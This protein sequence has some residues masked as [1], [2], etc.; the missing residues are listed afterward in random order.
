MN[1]EETTERQGE[2]VNALDH[3]VSELA[4][5]ARDAIEEFV[6]EQPHAALAIAAGVG[7]ILG[8]GLTPRRLIRLGLAVG[9]PALSGQFK[10]QIFRIAGDALENAQQSASS[11]KKKAPS[12][13]RRSHVESG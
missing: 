8:G 1:T 2:E 6:D 5:R 10:D 3:D 13:R 12:R 9:G 4:S 11:S 7:F